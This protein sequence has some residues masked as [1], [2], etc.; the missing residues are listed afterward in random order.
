MKAYRAFQWALEDLI[1]T[2]IA[3]AFRDS[4]KIFDELGEGAL[5]VEE[6]VENVLYN[7][8]LE[9]FTFFNEKLA[10]K[11]CSLYF[12]RRGLEI[13]W[14]VGENL[15]K[16]D[17]LKEMSFFDWDRWFYTFNFNNARKEF[18]WLV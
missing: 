11:V 10:G 17:R 13:L 4:D 3:S 16:V 12:D 6:L 7:A 2:R 5:T 1:I 18:M 8:P 15:I 9:G 14:F